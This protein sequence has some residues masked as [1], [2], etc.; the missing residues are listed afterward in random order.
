ML[1]QSRKAKGR[2]LQKTICKMIVEAF[3]ELTE[4]DVTSRSMGSPGSDCVMSPLAQELF[5]IT[6]ECKNTKSHP[7]SAA[8]EQASYNIYKGTIPVVA[9]HPPRVRM[10]ESI[11]IMRYSDLIKLVKTLKENN[12]NNVS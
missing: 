2:N 7:G 8:L 12:K 1:S 6:T 3:S 4:D 5:P 10:E 9:W 11:A